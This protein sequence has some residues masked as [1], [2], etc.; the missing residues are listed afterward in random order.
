MPDAGNELAPVM[1]SKGPFR[2]YE[3]DFLSL[4]GQLTF[5]QQPDGRRVAK[6]EFLAYVFD[7]KG[8][9]LATAGQ[10]LTLEP[11]TND[12]SRLARALIQAHL[13]ISV[14]DRAE[15]FLRI[16][17]RDVTSNKLGVIE[18][19]TS[20]LTSLPP[21]TNAPA[22]PAGSEPPPAPASPAGRSTPPQV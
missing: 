4:P 10:V 14:P 20:A 13:E 7:T 6:V 12:E 8:Y 17:I 19:P 11:R 2:R 5:T 9:L 3:L 1:P 22:A 18:I 16:G 15:T 21:A